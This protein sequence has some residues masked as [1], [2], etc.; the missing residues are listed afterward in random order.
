MGVPRSSY[1]PISIPTFSSSSLILDFFVMP[2]DVSVIDYSFTVSIHN[3]SSSS[4]GTQIGS[5]LA[6]PASVVDGNNTFTASG[7]TLNG[8]TTY[9]VQVR[10]GTGS[11]DTAIGRTSSNAEDSGSTSGWSIANVGRYYDTT[12]SSWQDLESGIS[13]R[14]TINA[15]TIVETLTPSQITASG[16]R[17]TIGGH[18]GAWW[19]KRTSPTP[20]GSCQSVSAGTTAV[21]LTGLSAG[22]SYTYKAYS[23]SGCGDAN[24]LTSTTFTTG[25]NLGVSKSSN[26]VK[27]SWDVVSGASGYE[28]QY[29]PYYRNPRFRGWSQA[30][31]S[32][33]REQPAGCY[34]Q[35]TNISGTYYTITEY[36]HPGI[37]Y[38]VRVRTTGGAWSLLPV[39]FTVDYTLSPSERAAD[40]E[41][42]LEASRLR[43]SLNRISGVGVSNMGGL[44][45]PDP[46]ADPNVRDASGSTSDVRDTT[47]IVSFRCLPHR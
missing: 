4:P 35:A 11:S 31:D 15:T 40:P 3:A 33:S 16:A 14:F 37:T 34:F 24:E 27:V 13:L 12:S 21:N 47:G 23:A 43:T 38:E 20:A 1:S 29:R 46:P 42:G 9:F 28:V 7:I 26:A 25:Y 6:P 22:T 44:E 45:I 32:N 19:Y 41:I 10:R 5:N 39:R 36:L 17:L 30:C 8:G 18:T 2:L